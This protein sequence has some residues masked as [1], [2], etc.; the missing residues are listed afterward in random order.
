MTRDRPAPAN[1]PPPFPRAQRRRYIWLGVALLFAAG[2]STTS[3]A[4]LAL[5]RDGWNALVPG[6]T[7]NPFVDFPWWVEATCGLFLVFIGC[8]ATIRLLRSASR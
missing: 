5:R 4:L 7:T 6:E 1:S 8:W 2:I 3:Q